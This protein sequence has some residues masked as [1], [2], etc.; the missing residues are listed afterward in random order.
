MGGNPNGRGGRL[1]GI[2]YD[3][4]YE[5]GLSK[6]REDARD[7]DGYDPTR[8]RIYRSADRGYESRYG[9]RQ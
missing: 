1:N 6:G 3:N 8:H 7:R 4:G 2:A 5:D 9:T